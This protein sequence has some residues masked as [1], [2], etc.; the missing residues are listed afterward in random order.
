MGGLVSEASAFGLGHDPTVLGWSP[1]LS[2]SLL[3]RESVSPSPSATPLPVVSLSLSQ[4]N[5]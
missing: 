3:S 1:E 5:K 4:I 2:G